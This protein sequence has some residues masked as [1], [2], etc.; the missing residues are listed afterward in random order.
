MSQNC[1]ELLQVFRSESRQKFA[2]DFIVAE[3]GF[4]CPRPRFRN[5]SATPTI[6]PLLA[7]VDHGP[8]ETLSP[9]ED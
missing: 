8:R 7:S 1:D 6:I 4:D 2:I 5:L 3:R 9:A